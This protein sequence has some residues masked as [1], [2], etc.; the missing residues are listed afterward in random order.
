MLL[1]DHCKFF[2]RFAA[3]QLFVDSS[4]I[5]LSSVV[6]NS[7]L[8]IEE[9][10]VLEILYCELPEEI[11]V[12]ALSILEYLLSCSISFGFPLSPARY[13]T[14]AHCKQLCIQLL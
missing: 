9:N 6:G 2:S 10:V 7:H 13:E 1:E 8:H 3:E 4:D 14:L 5:C 11:L 12:T